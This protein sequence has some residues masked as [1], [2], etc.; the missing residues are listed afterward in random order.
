MLNHLSYM[1]SQICHHYILAHDPP[2]DKWV[3]GDLFFV[4]FPVDVTLNLWNPSR[5]VGLQTS[6]SKVHQETFLYFLVL[7]LKKLPLQLL[8]KHYRLLNYFQLITPFLIL[9]LETNLCSNPS[10]S[11]NFYLQVRLLIELICLLVGQY[12]FQKAFL[13]HKN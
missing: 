7:S 2:I 3:K 4:R 10:C 11:K 9:V 13:P 12:R 6:Q 5:A 8:L 1:N